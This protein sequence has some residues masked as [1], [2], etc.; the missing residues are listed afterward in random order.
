MLQT[1]LRLWPDIGSPVAP[2]L[3][4]SVLSPLGLPLLRAHLTC[5]DRLLSL[6]RWFFFFM[7]GHL[8]D[9]V[10][11]R[12][13]KTEKVW[14]SNLTMQHVRCFPLRLRGVASRHA[15]TASAAGEGLCSHQ[16]GLRG[17]LHPPHVLPHPCA[18]SLTT[19]P[20]S[21][22]SNMHALVSCLAFTVKDCTPY[23]D[24]RASC[25][26]CVLQDCF[27]RPIASAPD[28][29]IDVLTRTPVNGQKCAPAIFHHP[30]TPLS[31]VR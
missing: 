20:L 13:E 17:L 9:F 12:L 19:S 7:F 6:C 3:S 10:R 4:E 21:L 8:R 29:V 24:A 26:T 30:N 25:V 18:L 27:N 11:Q 14:D 28:R 16:A 23:V 1:L 2:A 31:T 22:M 5:T 15:S